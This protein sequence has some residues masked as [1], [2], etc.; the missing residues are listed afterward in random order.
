MDL[1]DDR[2]KL[3]VRYSKEYPETSLKELSEIITL[4]TGKSL[5][6]SGINHRLR[7]VRELAASFEKMN[8]KNQPG[9]T[10]LAEKAAKTFRIC[11]C[12][13]TLKVGG[14]KINIFFR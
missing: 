11:N 2:T 6:K 3:A 10:G 7:K 12:L 9:R 14:T 5:S 13:L 8:K 4:E 1:L